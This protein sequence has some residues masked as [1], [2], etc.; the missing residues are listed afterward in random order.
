MD[1]KKLSFNAYLL[2]LFINDSKTFKPEKE[3]REFLFK[4]KDKDHFST[5]TEL[6]K[7]RLILVCSNNE[8]ESNIIEFS[9]MKCTEIAN[10]YYL[11]KKVYIERIERLNN[12]FNLDSNNLEQEFEQLTQRI[13]IKYLDRY[14]KQLNLFQ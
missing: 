13:S 12:Q 11:G 1:Y 14:A 2:L 10:Y 6:E 7:E 9:S 4:L 8:I 3:I 5:I